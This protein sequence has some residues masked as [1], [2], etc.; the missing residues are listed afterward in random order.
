M[1][2]IILFK[3]K[4]DCCGC[5]ACMN[6]CPKSAITMVPDEFGFIYP[7]IDDLKCIECGLCKKTCG[8]QKE[9]HKVKNL[10]TWVAVNKAD[11][12]LKKSASGGAFSAIAKEVL[13][14]GGM[15]F[16]CAM[17]LESGELIPKHIS[18]DRIEDLY[19]LQGSKYV[20]SFT[21]DSY[22]QVKKLLNSEKKVLFSGTPCQIVGLYAFLGSEEYKNLYTIDIIC[23]GVPNAKFFLDYL[24]ELEKKKN[25][26]ITSFIFRD[27]QNGWGLMA[28]VT[29][30]KQAGDMKKGLLNTKISSYYSLFL[31]SK[32]Y[33]INCYSCPYAGLSRPGNISIGDFWGI[34][35]Q[36]P[37]YL[38]GTKASIEKSKGVSCILVNNEHG[39]DL[40]QKYGN[41]LHLL[42]S[43]VDKA[44]ECNGQLKAPSPFSQD[45]EIIMQIY[46]NQGY[47]AVDTWYRKKVGIKYPVYIL[48]NAM[49]NNIQKTI[50]KL[51][52]H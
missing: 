27:K 52:K 12:V 42:P 25:G 18:I 5:S 51:L 44:A 28:S 26:T 31:S 33:R 1:S 35:K 29:Y 22:Q 24:K 36:H 2:K 20:Q 23:H 46:K 8:Y 15:V 19:K 39:T 13:A 41:N 11:E 49:P 32:I 7:Q 14:A 40:V 37:E 9:S 21:K 43:T 17:I 10:S 6:I 45:R 16:G 48:W 47:S 3:D 50:K 38:N 4:I 30:K 34:E